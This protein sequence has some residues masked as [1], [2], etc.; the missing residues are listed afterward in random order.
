MATI[1]GTDGD[2][3]V[4]GAADY[5]AGKGLGAWPVVGPG[6]GQGS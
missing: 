2:Q 6:M 5:G 1:R 3:G 4:V